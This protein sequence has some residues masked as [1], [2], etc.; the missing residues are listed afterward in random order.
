MSEVAYAASQVDAAPSDGGLSVVGVSKAFPGVQ[1]LSDVSFDVRPGEVHGLVGE[2]GAGKSTLMAIASGA[3]AADVGQVVINGEDLAQGGPDQARRLGL[4]IV[5][6]HPALMPDLTV[7]ENLYLAAPLG[8]RPSARSLNKWA[9]ARLRAWDESIVISPSA[10]VASLVPEEKFIVEISKALI[11]DPDVLI[12]DEPTEHLSTEDVTRLFQK[13]RVLREKNGAIVYISHRIHEVRQI[14]DRITVLRDGRTRGTHDTSS[15]DEARIVNMVVGRELA[16]T[17]PPKALDVAR[18]PIVLSVQGLSGSGFHDV[19]LEVQQG[20]VVGLAG[21]EGNGQREFLRA[22][23]GLNHGTGK[24]VIADVPASLGSPARARA[25]GIAYVPADR[26]H[27]G[28]VTAL[29]VRDNL[30]MRS[31]S[32][33]AGAGV[34]HSRSEQAAANA[35]VAAFSIKTPS[36]DTPIESLSGGNQQ[37]VVLASVLATRPRVLLADEPSQGVD[38]GAR[39]EIYELIRAAAADGTAVLVVSA[40]AVE[41]AGLCDRVLIFSRGVVVDEHAGEDVSERNVTGSVLTATSQRIR[42]KR[43]SKAI[44]WLAGP[45]APLASVLAVI[46][47]LGIWAATANSLYLS[48]RSLTGLLALTAALALVAFGQQFVMAVGGIDLSVGPLMGSLVVIESYYLVDNATVA[49]Q[50]AGWALLFGF[51]TLV[52]LL[53]WLMIE[54][55]GIQPMIATLIMF[56]ALQGL[57]LTL[58]PVPGGYISGQITDAITVAFRSVPVMAVIAV[59]LALTLE[60]F[61]YRTRRGMGLRATGSQPESA[62][63]AGI[64]PRRMRLMAYVGCSLCAALAAIPLL[65]QIGSGDPAAGISYTLASIAAVVIGGAS[66]FGGRGSFLGALLGALLICQVDAV[67]AFL[68][69]T[70]AWTSVLLGAMMLAAVAAYSKCRQLEVPR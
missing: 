5:H 60:Y 33:H 37:K 65:A 22:L 42:P 49:T 66:I 17:F 1:A 41:L 24:V 13:I 55:A 10:R 4:A 56:T 25:A 28:I 21:I 18:Q 64:S 38:V 39:M 52:G 46:V 2:N 58:R 32:D 70:E 31:L 62:R 67:T 63:K 59:G 44:S 57:S 54:L 34:V 36:L 30:S 14:S 27:E 11:G 15:L 51:A 3:L 8:H 9:S 6:Q 7:A 43:A 19:D 26:H 20:E 69:L 16:S 68:H 48:S 45:T 29:P 50:A 61:L 40:D 47:A 53:N 35:M 12:L 23:A